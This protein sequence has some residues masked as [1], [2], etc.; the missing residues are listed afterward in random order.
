MIRVISYTTSKGMFE[1]RIDPYKTT[2]EAKKDI[3][4]QNNIKNINKVDL[5]Y[6]NI[7]KEK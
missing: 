4:K 7:K 2:I 1:G 6:V 5:H 3:A